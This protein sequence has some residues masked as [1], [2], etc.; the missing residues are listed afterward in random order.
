M[1]KLIFTLLPVLALSQVGINTT[2]PTKTLDVNGEMRIREIPAGDSSDMILVVDQE[3]NIRKMPLPQS[4]PSPITP[5]TP[6]GSCPNFERNQSSGYY[7]LFK[8]DSSVPNPN[9]PLSI[10]NTN[11]T[12]AGAYI[13]NNN[14]FYSW[15]NTTGNALNIGQPF[16]VY[17]SPT[18]SCQY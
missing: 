10:N 6:S 1:Q 3:G 15:S 14:Y 16:T 5:V 17:F 12:S 18:M 9:S 4:S 2:L 11:F 7:L 13:L 8:S